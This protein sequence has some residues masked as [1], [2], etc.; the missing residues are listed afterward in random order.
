MQQVTTHQQMYDDWHGCFVLWIGWT[1]LM[2]KKIHVSKIR[3]T[4]LIW[5]SWASPKEFDLDGSDADGRPG[6]YT[7]LLR[8][9]ARSKKMEGMFGKR[10]RDCANYPSRRHDHTFGLLIVVMGLHSQM[11]WKEVK[12]KEPEI[13]WWWRITIPIFQNRPNE[14]NISNLT[15]ATNSQF[16]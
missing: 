5:L 4:D 14:V 11:I 8:A 1:W 2:A 15:L 12:V 13:W 3:D 7:R 10:R 6:H 16:S 9:P